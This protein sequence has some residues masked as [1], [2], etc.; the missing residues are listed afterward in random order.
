MEQIDNWEFQAAET[1]SYRIQ[2]DAGDTLEERVKTL[3][4]RYT[5]ITVFNKIYYK[6]F[7][8]IHE[9]NT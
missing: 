9:K 3:G 4:E 7:F 1:Y 2:S 5:T 8:K 6:D